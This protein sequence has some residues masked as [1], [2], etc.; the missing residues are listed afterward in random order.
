M[1]R[2][3]G[4]YLQNLRRLE[5]VETV[6]DSKLG[7]AGRAVR[8]VYVVRKRFEIWPDVRLKRRPNNKFLKLATNGHFNISIKIK[9]KTQP[10]T[11]RKYSTRAKDEKSTFSF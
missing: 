2:L 11:N 5:K 8:N 4:S 7:A 6:I 3:L 1:K 10:H 9:D